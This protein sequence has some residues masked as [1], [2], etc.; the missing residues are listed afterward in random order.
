MSSN[1]VYLNLP[2][3]LYGIL[4]VTIISACS[5]TGLAIVPLLTRQLFHAMMNMFQ[6]LAVG[7]LCGSAIFHLIPQVG[8]SLIAY[9]ELRLWYERPLITQSVDKSVRICLAL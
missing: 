4:S 9:L 8:F 5:L 2:V 6:G 3:W 7:S 1:E